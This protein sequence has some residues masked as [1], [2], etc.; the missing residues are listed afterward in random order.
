MILVL[1]NYSCNI[2]NMIPWKL[3]HNVFWAL[4]QGR[5]GHAQI[6]NATWISQVVT[7][8]LASTSCKHW[9]GYWFN[10]F[11]LFSG[12][13]CWTY[14]SQKL[15]HNTR[16][17]TF[18]IQSDLATIFRS[19]VHLSGGRPT[20]YIRIGKC[21]VMRLANVW[22][23]NVAD[24]TSLITEWIDTFTI[25]FLTY[26]TLSSLLNG[27]WGIRHTAPNAA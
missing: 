27:T 26:C 7:I 23:A 13:H 24:E 16:F 19:S 4:C 10:K 5:R 15:R 3:N 25:F 1:P 21:S 18:R 20:L 2:L 17:S 8:W 12:V 11:S 22:L 14:A 9:A 6:A